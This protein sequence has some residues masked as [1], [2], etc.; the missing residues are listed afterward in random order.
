ML[1]VK[2]I[3]V[4]SKFKTS[5]S[6]STSDFKFELKES[7]L[8]PTNIIAYIDNICIYKCYIYYIRYF[9]N[10]IPIL[11]IYNVISSSY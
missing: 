1:Q 4:D 9:M 11:L 5:D 8:L 3:Y 7:V 6:K 2:K 10:L